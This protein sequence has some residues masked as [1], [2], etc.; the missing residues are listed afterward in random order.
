M[1][2][3]QAVEY[4][5]SVGQDIDGIY[6]VS[7]KFIHDTITFDLNK[8]ISSSGIK[9]FDSSSKTAELKSRDSNLNDSKKRRLVTGIHVN[10]DLAFT[11]SNAAQHLNEFRRLMYGTKLTVFAPSHRPI[12]ELMLWQMLGVKLAN[13]GAGGSAATSLKLVSDIPQ[14][15]LDLY[16]TPIAFNADNG[17]EIEVTFP[18]GLTTAGTGVA[19]PIIPSA[20]VAYGNDGNPLLTEEGTCYSMI[21]NFHIIEWMSKKDQ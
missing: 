6:D 9:I 3:T 21:F 20:K 4:L 17:R 7:T 15:G 5:K 18:K 8:E 16:N 14:Q 10:T 13:N 11:V 2:Y 1:N 12:E 19:K